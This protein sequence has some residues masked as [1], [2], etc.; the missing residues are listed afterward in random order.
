MIDFDGSLRDGKSLQGSK[1]FLSILTDLNNTVVWTDSNPSPIPNSSSP[2]SKH[3]ET[4]PSVPNTSGIT[5]NLIFH[6][7]LSSLARSKY[8][9]LFSFSLIF[10]MSSVG[11]AKFTIR[12]VFYFY[13]FS[14]GQ[15]ILLGLGDTIVS[16]NLSEFYFSFC[17]TDS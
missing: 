17:K 6:N 14:L 15:V 2:L 3:L 4:V 12:Q 5:V 1:T 8:L 10:T 9:S 13:K 7:F 11:M 16:Q